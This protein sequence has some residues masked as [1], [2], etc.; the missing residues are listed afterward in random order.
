MATLGSLKFHVENQ[1]GYGEITDR[2]DLKDHFDLHLL[3]LEWVFSCRGEF[4]ERLFLG[5]GILF[6]L[7]GTKREPIGFLLEL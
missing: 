3:D 7:W 1:A 6:W 5:G 2:I 4:F